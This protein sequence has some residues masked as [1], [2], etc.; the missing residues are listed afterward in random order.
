MMGKGAQLHLIN[1]IES[2]GHVDFSAEVTAALRVTDGAMVAVDSIEG[3]AVQAETM[4][5]TMMI[6]NGDQLHL[7]NQI[8]S[9]G[10]VDFF[11][12]V[13]AA[14]RITDGA[15]I[16][17]DCI[18]GCAVQAE[19]MLRQAPQERAKP[20]LFMNK[21]DRCILELQM[22]PEDM[23]SRFRKSLKDVN[24][25]IATYNGEHG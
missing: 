18:E 8:Y 23:Y 24:V 19:T 5:R 15:M 3:C 6:D 2:P 20:C 12:E 21:V 10:H 16:V 9:P 22:D 25:F 14:L 4:L 7:I 11:S 17:V 1:L 13:T